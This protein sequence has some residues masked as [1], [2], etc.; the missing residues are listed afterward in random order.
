MTR[1]EIIMSII[2]GALVLAMGLITG[3]Q[4]MS[5]GA[6]IAASATIGA[7]IACLDGDDPKAS[8]RKRIERCAGAVAV[9]VGGAVEEIEALPD[10]VVEVPDGGDTPRSSDQSTPSPRGPPD[11]GVDAAPASTAIRRRQTAAG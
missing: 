2:I 10:P 6:R 7:A 11:G 1:R 5:P 9:E 8:K 3:C 4:S